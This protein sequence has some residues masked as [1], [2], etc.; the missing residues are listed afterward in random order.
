[1][2]RSDLIRV[3]RNTE[4]TLNELRKHGVS[5]WNAT[6]DWQS[7]L[8]SGADGRKAKGDPSDPTYAAAMSVLQGFD[9]G[10]ET[11]H[12]D[13][14]ASIER[15]DAAALEVAARFRQLMPL[16]KNDPSIHRGRQNTV[17]ACIVCSGPA[18]PVRRGMCEAD[19]RAWLRA[20]RPDLEG[21]KRQRQR[22]VAAA[23]QIIHEHEVA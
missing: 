12:D 4:H 2:N 7:S 16:D 20:D 23:A 21:F 8:R 9:R 1:M 6:A 22:E 17:P 19:Y 10:L 15:L 13:F 18:F 5:L 3:A 11:A 14:K